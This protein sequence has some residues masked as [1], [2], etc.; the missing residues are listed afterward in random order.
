MSS[1]P[2]ADASGE[3]SISRGRRRDL[4]SSRLTPGES[5]RTPGRFRRGKRGS[6]NEKKRARSPPPLPSR[7][8]RRR[9]ATPLADNTS[10]AQ[11]RIG[12]SYAGREE[13]KTRGKSRKTRLQRRPTRER[14]LRGRRWELVV[15]RIKAISGTTPLSRGALRPPGLSLRTL[16]SFSVSACPD[17]TPIVRSLS[18]FFPVLFVALRTNRANGRRDDF[19]PVQTPYANT[20]LSIFK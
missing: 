1:A 17:N 4:V 8:V 15:Y 5:C 2:I 12:E 20:T 11:G 19:S 10:R 18:L 13:P 9:E 16:E 3:W 14:N 7:L 6:E